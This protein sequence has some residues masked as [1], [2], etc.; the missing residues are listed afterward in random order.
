MNPGGTV[1]KQYASPPAMTIDGAKK[2]RA[3]IETSAG[4]MTA[5]LLP[6]EAPMTVN[7]FVFLARDGYYDGVIFHRV[8]P[9]FMIQGGDPTGTGRGG[10][11]YRLDDEPVRLSYTRGTLAMA[12]AGP[13]TNG[14][15]F[16]IMH[17]DYGLPPNYTIFG[18]LTDGL[19]V[20]DAIATAPRGA[21]DRP[22]QPTEIKRVT[23]EEA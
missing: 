9:G 17:A 7:N 5:D 2:Y 3:T 11:G 16:F 4:T 14:S 15:Q 23:I 13:N 21:Q 18:R 19:E 6:G 1:A 20:V 8:I 12:N 10:P 22:D